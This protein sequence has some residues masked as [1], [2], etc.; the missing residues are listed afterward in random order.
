[1]ETNLLR[2]KIFEE[3]LEDIEAVA[4]ICSPTKSIY[5]TDI[6]HKK[7]KKRPF[8]LK[9]RPDKKKSKSKKSDSKKKKLVVKLNSNN[10]KINPSMMPDNS[11]LSYND[12]TATS[13]PLKKIKPSLPE[14]SLQ[15]SSI[16]Q[17]SSP[18]FQDLANITLLQ[19]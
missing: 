10:V 12:D 5:H 15:E 18:L 17:S 9:R 13:P 3:V 16:Q 1:M 2:S 8:G 4:E 11:T 19:K 14:S 6:K 7:K